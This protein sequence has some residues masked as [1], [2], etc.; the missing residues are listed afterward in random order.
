MQRQSLKARILDHAETRLLEQ[1]FRGMRV[2]ELARDVGISKRTLYEQFRTKEE[3]AREAL[4]RLTQKLQE[5]IEAILAEPNHEAVQLR[6]VVFRICE[7]YSRARPPFY[8]DLETTPS[9][10][11]LV[12]ASRA[13]SFAQVEDL[14]RSGMANG[15]FRAELEPRLVRRTLIAAVDTVIRPEVLVQDRLSLEQ[16]FDAIIDLILNGMFGNTQN[17]C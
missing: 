9:L 5:T 3:M 12:E 1:G 15:N 11:E 4:I 14:V 17:G 13:R 6:A 16:A 10:I 8:R 7:T 2:D